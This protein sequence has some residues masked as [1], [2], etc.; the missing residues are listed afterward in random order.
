M[1]D[2]GCDA[3]RPLIRNQKNVV[4]V[5]CSSDLQALVRPLKIHLTHGARP[6][7][8]MLKRYSSENEQLQRRYVVDL[9]TLGLVFPPRRIDWVSALSVV[10]KNHLLCTVSIHY[11]P[12]NKATVKHKWP[13]P[14]IN[15]EIDDVCCAKAFATVDSRSGYWQ[16]PMLPNSQTLHAFMTP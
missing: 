7:R 11:R 15:A 14:H 10:Q 12:S 3:W 2:T 4:R 13:T 9:Q 5:R 16:L 1:T 8:A 6:I